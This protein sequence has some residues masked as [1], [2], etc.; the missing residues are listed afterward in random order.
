MFRIADV[1]A[2]GSCLAAVNSIFALITGYVAAAR[3][4]PAFTGDPKAIVRTEFIDER[5]LPRR[6]IIVTITRDT[7][8]IHSFVKI[9]IVICSVH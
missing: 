9:V 4:A 2:P 7:L 1:T 5:R 3:H 8:S 6:D